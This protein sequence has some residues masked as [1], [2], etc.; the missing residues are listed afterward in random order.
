MMFSELYRKANAVLNPRK[1]SEYASAGGVG[2][3]ILS[4]G[5]TV[6]TGVCIDTVR[7]IR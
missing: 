5:G 4:E 7:M 2:A 1:L 3:A 6:Y